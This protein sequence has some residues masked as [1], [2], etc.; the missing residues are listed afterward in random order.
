MHLQADPCSNHNTINAFDERGLVIN[1]KCYTNSMLISQTLLQTWAPNTLSDLCLKHITELITFKPDVI[2]IG[3]GHDLQRPKPDLLTQ[4]EALDIPIEW[5]SSKQ[6]CYS[7]M[8]I[9]SDQR[10]V[11]AALLIE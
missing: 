7:Y 4:I 2:L 1:Q 6:A 8:A 9:M 11:L 10:R 5:M 3:T